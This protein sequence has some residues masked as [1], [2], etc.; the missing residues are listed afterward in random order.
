MVDLDEFKDYNDEHGH[1][2]GDELLAKSAQSWA[3]AV[4]ATDMVARYGGDE[5]SVILPNCP[6][7]EATTVVERMRVATPKPVTCSAGIACT[8]GTE[9]A[10]AVVRRA[11]SALYAAKRS[12]RDLT[13]PAQPG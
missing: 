6:I 7:D 9:P 4:R 12:G 10:E 2:A 11:D 1:L 8:D 5:F 3:H 13:T